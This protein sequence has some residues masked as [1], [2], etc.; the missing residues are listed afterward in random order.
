MKNFAENSLLKQLEISN[1]Q[2]QLSSYSSA[3]QR[4]RNALHTERRNLQAAEETL[5][6]MRETSDEAETMRNVGL[7]LLAIPVI[8]WIAGE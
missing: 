1:L 4:Y 2:E 5:D 6:M 8:G 7:G 3:L